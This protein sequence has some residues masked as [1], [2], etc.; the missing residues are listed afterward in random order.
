MASSLR[1]SWDWA[2][3]AI[4]TP[5]PAEPELPVM[6]GLPLAFVVAPALLLLPLPMSG[7]VRFLTGLPMVWCLA[8]AAFGA[9]ALGW[10]LWRGQS[11][12]THSW[13]V[14]ASTL[15]FATVSGFAGFAALNE[16]R[17]YGFPTL[18][19]I[20]AVGHLI[21]VQQLAGPMPH[22]YFGMTAFQATA[23]W[24][25]QLGTGPF[26]A[27]WGVTYALFAAPVGYVALTQ[28]TLAQDLRNTLGSS[29]WAWLL[30]CAVLL[31]GGYPFFACVLPLLHG[32]QLDGYFPQLHGLV[33]L[34]V[35]ALLYGVV[36]QRLVRLLGLALCVVLLRFTY[37]L[38]V[39]DLLVT[40]AL[41]VAWEAARDEPD[42]Q[43]RRRLAGLAVLGLLAAVYPYV[44]LYGIA[45]NGGGIPA[46][47]MPLR[48]LATAGLS[49]LLLAAP[50]W[51][52]RIS[53]HAPSAAVRRLSAFVGTYG[54]V[55]VAV[56]GVWLTAVSARAHTSD[57]LY[58]LHKYGFSACLLGL[59]TAIG[60]AAYAV[61]LAVASPRRPVLWRRALGAVVIVTGVEAGSC[62]H[63]LSMPELYTDTFRARAA[64]AP[65][66]TVA[67]ADL[68][69]WSAIQ[70]VLADPSNRFGAFLAPTT[71][72]THFTGYALRPIDPTAPMPYQDETGLPPLL[73]FPLLQ[74][75]EPGQCV[76]WLAPQPFEVVAASDATG[77]ARRDAVRLLH[78]GAKQCVRF[79]RRSAGPKPVELCTTCFRGT[80]QQVRLD[81]ATQ[82]PSP[83]QAAA[84]PSQFVGELPTSSRAS[85]ERCSLRVNAPLAPTR[86]LLGSNPLPAIVPNRFALPAPPL[87]PGAS[88]TVT[89]VFAG[90]VP[91]SATA[92]PHGVGLALI[93][94]RA[95]PP[96]EEAA[97]GRRQSRPPDGEAGAAP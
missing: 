71:A 65:S 17:T 85:G 30:T 55:A 80:V 59:L 91:K 28:A 45:D 81:A 40:V 90:P 58:L 68:A 5:R 6:R 93:C 1:R 36:R 87:P 73:D 4:E 11:G 19:A 12:R 49:C 29:H 37:L 39:V 43:R 83:A 75:I 86:L 18:G 10:L 9:G 78:R 79:E 96:S 64:R 41:L 70:R 66:E 31:V 95:A 56:Q 21:E 53:W 14:W 13:Q 60:V 74:V 76:F 67:L 25:E 94:V 97:S 54:V 3:A 16:P 50:W 82:P 35:A 42:D 7:A 44:R 32:Y 33:P 23:Y 57:D 51:I 52:E 48:L 69:A 46:P 38:N 26:W 77:S 88:H 8:I 84:G 89:V 2:Q 72:E 61:V 47:N 27:F 34:F 24:L 22:A 15:A 92:A 62:G 20:D 63:A